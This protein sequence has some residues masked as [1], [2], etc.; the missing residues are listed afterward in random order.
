MSISACLERLAAAGID[1][2]P[3]ESFQTHYVFSRDGF[4][5]LVE[6]AGDGFGAIG[7]A[8]LVTEAGFAALVWRGGRPFFVSRG[9][10]Q[11]ATDHDV[12]RLRAFAADLERAIR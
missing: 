9:H 11:P 10:E 12:E 5:A 7:S 8:G 2:L 4:A 6:R 3:I 1:L